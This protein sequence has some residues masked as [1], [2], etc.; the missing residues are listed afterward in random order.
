M[1][2]LIDSKMDGISLQISEQARN[3]GLIM[4]ATMHYTC[5][6]KTLIRRAFC[7][8]KLVYANRHYLNKKCKIIL[9]ESLVISHLNYAS[10]VFAPAITNAD[11]RWLQLVQNCCVRLICGLRRS[12]HITPAL[13]D[14]GWLPTENGACSSQALFHSIINQKIS[15]YLYEYKV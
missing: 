7:N 11:M 14:L 2:S 8:L 9:C 6:V 10:P 5:Q 15:I 12:G 1:S 4:D 3:L 13:R